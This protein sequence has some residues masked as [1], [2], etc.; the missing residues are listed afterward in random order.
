MEVLLL[1]RLVPIGA[2]ILGVLALS[3]GQTLAGAV[4]LGGAVLMWQQAQG[5]GSYVP[6][7]NATAI[8]G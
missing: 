3:R 6:G 8:P 4:A 7:G 2:G 1:E 5:G